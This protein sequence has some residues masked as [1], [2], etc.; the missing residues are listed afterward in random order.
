MSTKNEP[1]KEIPDDGPRK[2]G[3]WAIPHDLSNFWPAPAPD[4]NELD[5]VQ[6]FLTL[7]SQDLEDTGIIAHCDDQD[8]T[9]RRLVHSYELIREKFHEAVGRK[10]KHKPGSPADTLAHAI[11]LSEGLIFLALK[12]QAELDSLIDAIKKKDQEDEDWKKE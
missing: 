8:Y 5:I 4:D 1:E 12:Y 10:R 7:M 11:Y 9:I 2:N 6:F 3:P